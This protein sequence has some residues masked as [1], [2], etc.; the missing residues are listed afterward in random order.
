MLRTCSISV[1]FTDPRVGKTSSPDPSPENIRSVS[2][3]LIIGLVT[4][5]KGFILSSS[6]MVEPAITLS[7]GTDSVTEAV[8]RKQR[9]S[10]E[11]GGACIPEVS[12]GGLR[13]DIGIHL[14]SP[15]Q[16]TRTRREGKKRTQ[17]KP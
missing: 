1:K 14:S 12:P 17:F 2:D 8:E 13:G 6:L 9:S 5:G 3:S 7:A 16:G 4:L 11:D 15:L 10:G